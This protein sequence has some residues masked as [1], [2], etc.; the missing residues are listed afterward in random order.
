MLGDIIRNARKGKY[1]T[2][3]PIVE[4]LS[5]VI[6]YFKSTEGEIV[7]VE[8]GIDHDLKRN[9]PQIYSEKAIKEELSQIMIPAM[10]ITAWNLFVQHKEL[11]EISGIKFI[12]TEPGYISTFRGFKYHEIEDV[13]MN[14]IHM[15]LDLI[16]DTIA[17]TPEMFE[18]ILNWFSFIIQNPGLKTETALVILGI[19][20]CG[21]NTFTNV[22]C[23]LLSGYSKP[24]LDDLEKL[25]GRFNYVIENKMLI[26]CNEIKTA[27]KAVNWGSMKTIITDHVKTI[28]QKF[29]P[30]YDVENVVNLIIVSNNAVPIKIENGDRRYVITKCNGLMT[31]NHDYWT[32]LNAEINA[33]GFYDHLFTFF[34]RRDISQFQSRIIPE[35]DTRND[36]ILDSLSPI[37]NIILEHCDE[38]I[39]GIPCTAALRYKTLE[40]KTDRRFELE[41]KTRCNHVRVKI[42]G[43]LIW[44]YKLRE[45]CIQMFQQLKNK[46]S[47]DELPEDNEDF[48]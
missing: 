9:V 41:M 47:I 21:K 11:F 2:E 24:N 39:R 13:D 30:V 25:T 35:T 31:G 20:G 44:T 32:A 17:Q 40:F 28:E 38:F 14:R 3:Q 6:R 42:D 45:D 16:R 26:V 8:K 22:L 36:M 34:R 37:D 33:P 12:S 19:Q 5:K 18:Y 48:N 10:K 46:I 29:K 23:E 15:Y 27:D 43:K 7:Y 4:D 1:V